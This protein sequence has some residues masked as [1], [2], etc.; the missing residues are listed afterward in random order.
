MAFHFEYVEALNYDGCFCL[1]VPNIHISAT[2]ASFEGRAFDAGERTGCLTRTVLVYIGGNYQ[3]KYTDCQQRRRLLT[4][5][6]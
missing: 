6:Q 2:D 4:V 3:G 5:Y 1:F